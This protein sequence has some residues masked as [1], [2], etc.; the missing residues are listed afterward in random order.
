MPLTQF[1]TRLILIGILLVASGCARSPLS[2]AQDNA[3]R[4]ME[5]LYSAQPDRDVAAAIKKKDYRFVGLYGIGLDVPY[6][7]LG[8]IS[9]DAD[10]RPIEGTSDAVLGY[11]HAK[12]IAIAHV[13]AK[14]FNFRMRLFR[15]E[16][17]GFKCDL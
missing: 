15:A 9:V 14:E 2:V 16:N 17:M 13:Y 6:I 5:W 4:Q 11:E 8:C 3:V 10:V 12:L 7:N 1:C